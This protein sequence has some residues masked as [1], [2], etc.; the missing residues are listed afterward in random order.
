[1][2][3]IITKYYI[4]CLWAFILQDLHAQPTINNIKYD[5]YTTKYNTIQELV[6]LV[7]TKYNT[8]VF[9][10]DTHTIARDNNMQYTVPIEYK[11]NYYSEKDKKTKMLES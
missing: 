3:S 7:H 9:K 4:I 5:M 10:R 2:L 6:N 8:F 1:M 11:L